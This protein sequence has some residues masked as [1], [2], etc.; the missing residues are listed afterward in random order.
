MFRIRIMMILVAVAPLSADG[1]AF[2]GTLFVTPAGSGGCSTWADACSL[3]QA[4]SAASATTSDELWVQAGVYAP[5]TLK[6]GVKVIGGFAG[7][8]TLASQ[9]DPIA[10]ETIVDGNGASQCVWSTANPATT[11]LRG[12]TITGGWVDTYDGG[13]GLIAQDTSALMVECVFRGNHA[14]KL[15]AAVAIRGVGSPQFINC[16]FHDNG[17]GTGNSAQPLGGAAVYLYSGTPTFTN[18]LFYDNTAMEA[19]GLLV[20]EG[21]APSLIQCTFVNNTATF[22]HGGALSDMMGAAMVRNSV[23]W[24]NTAAQSGDQILSGSNSQTIV[25]FSDVQG[26]WPGILNLDA[27]PLFVDEAA[28]DFRLQTT[29]PCL[30]VGQWAALPADIG[31]LDWDGATTETTPLDLARQNRMQGGTQPDLGAFETAGS[32]GG[33]GGKGGSN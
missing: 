8:E 9:S 22:G 25:M 18:C 5:F 2:G 19:A 16:K 21:G 32:S 20:G 6:D 11:V 24:G 10:N 12:F 4:L 29:S 17:T 13:G 3:T 14:S 31:D 7:S 26:G 27:D 30:Q 28:K 23:F 33:G 1:T 15:G